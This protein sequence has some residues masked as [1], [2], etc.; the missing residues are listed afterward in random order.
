MNNEQGTR[1]DEGGIGIRDWGGFVILGTPVFID[2]SFFTFF[3]LPPFMDQY[4]SWNAP[5]ESQDAR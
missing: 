5:V 2:S 4:A 1:N 3:Y